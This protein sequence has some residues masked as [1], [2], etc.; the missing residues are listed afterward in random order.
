MIDLM[1]LSIPFKKEYLLES[2]TSD[3][4]S[5]VY[6]DLQRVASLAGLR[7]NAFTVEVELK[8]RDADDDYLPL[9]NGE[10]FEHQV[11]E[12]KHSVSGL[13]HPF[14]SLPSYW[15]G[16][17]MKI[18]AGGA[19]RLPSVEIK[20]SPAKVLQGHN[21]FGSDDLELCGFELLFIL[22]H[23][24]PDLY[25]MLFIPETT[26]DWLDVTF[27][28]RTGSEQLALQSMNALRNISSG[29]MKAS[30]QGRSY[31]STCYWN[32]GSR[33]CERKAYLKL[34]ELK[35]EIAELERKI[36]HRS[37]A[38]FI[39]IADWPAFR[40]HAILTDERLIQWSTGLVRFEARLKQRWLQEFGLPFR[41]LDAVDYQKTYENDGEKNLIAD[42]WR[43]SFKELTSA[44]KGTSMNIYH[45]EKIHNE[46]KKVYFSYSR[47]GNITY[48]KANRLFGFYRRLVNE[49]FTA[50][51]QTMSK[52]T[53]NDQVRLMI[54]IGISKDQLQ[55]LH[56]EKN[57]N[58]IPLIRMIDINF[59][60]QVPDWYEEPVSRY[61]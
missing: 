14:E 47:S 49:G 33:H 10:T 26:L 30:N 51:Q 54:N 20:A 37:K 27:S 58:V 46:L 39:P 32:K 29:Q 31:E 38:D 48:A 17:A 19:M 42:M 56:G 41:F 45:D 16:V 36:T 52:S 34:D 15:T 21:V 18:H 43:A 28:A 59:G 9:P 6:V 23:S 44:I 60:Q 22:A 50:V 1:K 13:T 25:E 24:M 8:E 53:F 11:D 3:Y 57:S 35:R 40:R 4:C 12:Y 5:G 55:Q 7:L 61:A 2:S